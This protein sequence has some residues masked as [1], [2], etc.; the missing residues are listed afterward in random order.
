[1]P[2][3]KEG[4]KRGQTSLSTVCLFYRIEGKKGNTSLAKAFIKTSS[5]IKIIKISES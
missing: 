2:Y 4:L 5:N 3:V 1:M